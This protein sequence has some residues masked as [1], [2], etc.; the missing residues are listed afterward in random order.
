MHTQ[1]KK[2]VANDYSKGNTNAYPNDI[3]KALTL[4]NEY[5]PLKLDTS[6]IPA[7]GTAFVTGAKGNKKKGGDKAAV[8]DKYLKASEWNALSLE[9]QAKIIETRKKSKANDD[10]DKSTKSTASS[11][12]IKSLSKMLKSLEKNNQ[13]L[14]RS[15]SVL[16]KCEEDDDSNLSIS[17]S[18]G[19]SQFQ[20]AL[21]MLQEHNP[22]IVLAL[23]SRSLLIWI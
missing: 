9:A 11:K 8:S 20:K 6:T 18:E 14:K 2:D 16:Q 13:K 15:V 12:S 22:K 21:E 17:S 5:K 10:D 19:T 3:H 1:L 23:K 7:Q 4:M